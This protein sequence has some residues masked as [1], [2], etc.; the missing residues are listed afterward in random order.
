[1]LIGLFLREKKSAYDP[2][3]PNF[4]RIEY[5]HCCLSDMTFTSQMI[6]FMN[7]SRPLLYFIYFMIS[8]WKATLGWNGLILI[9]LLPMQLFCT[10]GKHQKT[11]RFKR[12]EKGCIG[13]KWINKITDT[14]TILLVL[15]P[16]FRIP[17]AHH[18]EPIT[19]YVAFNPIWINLPSNF[20]I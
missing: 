9:H 19:F 12:V 3:H 8:V 1:M 2:L 11:V 6:T 16:Y 15:I 4:L 7:H 14:K 17:T 10:P 13:N 5:T 18:V 20:V